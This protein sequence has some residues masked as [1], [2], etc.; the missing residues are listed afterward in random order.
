M[1]FSVP[2]L[3]FIGEP[4]TGVLRPFVAGAALFL[5]SSVPSTRRVGEYGVT[6]TVR[7]NSHG[8]EVVMME[9]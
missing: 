1:P 9:M 8:L 6:A 5:S 3:C 7:E 4:F 2:S